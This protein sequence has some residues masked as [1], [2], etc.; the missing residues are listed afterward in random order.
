METIQQQFKA[1]D[2]KFA[3]Y[4]FEGLL[5]CA[6]FADCAHK[7]VGML[8]LGGAPRVSLDSLR[9]RL[10]GLGEVSIREAFQFVLEAMIISQHF[11][12]AVNRPRR[13]PIRRRRSGRPPRP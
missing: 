13:R 12:T 11:S 10:V 4:A 6:A 5:I 9:R 7:D 8:R 3:H 1:G 2:L